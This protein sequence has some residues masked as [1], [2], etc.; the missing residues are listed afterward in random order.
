MSERTFKLTIAALGGE[1]GGVLTDWLIAIAQEEGYLVQST[2]VPGV[3]QRTGATIYYLEFFP[4]A[5]AASA[6]REPVMALMPVPGDVDCVVASELAEAGR[7]I[8]RGLVTRQTTLI[9]S[10]HRS[11][12]ISEKSA[13]GN[14]ATDREQLLELVRAQGGR[15]I[16]FDMQALAERRSAVVSAVL[17]GAI[18]GAGVLPFAKSAFEHAIT[19]AGIAVKTNMA[20]F[21]DACQQAQTGG[22]APSKPVGR[23]PP[24]PERARVAALQPLLD[25]VRQ[26][27]ERAQATALEGVRRTLDYQDRRYAE[28]YL[29]RL[30]A[31]AALETQAPSPERGASPQ[32]GTLSEAAARSLALWMTFEDPL[33]VA[34]LKCRGERFERIRTEIRAAPDKL[35]GITDF[36]KPRVAEIADTLPASWGRAVLGSKRLTRWLGHFTGGKH[37]RTSTVGGFCLLYAL[38][39][40]RRFRRATLRY[41][42]ENQR[43]EAWLG[44][45]SRLAPRNYALAVE[46]ARSQRLIKGY[47]ETHERGWA[48]FSRL[49][50]HLDGLSARPDGAEWLARLQDAALADEEGRQ[51]SQTLG[52]LA[53]VR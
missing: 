13:L 50:A 35:F 44:E 12:A 8:Q 40:M 4:G 1:G 7:A 37:I 2:S 22:A 21:E 20:A 29:S 34:Q 15:S 45:L 47:G 9:A 43:I 49:L 28:L 18:C 36:L 48:N 38:S 39:G 17:L 14:G 46:L 51:L 41:E 32:H 23:L 24:L 52:A 6:A 33:R 3:A 5:L 53:Q 19:A 16:L 25:R 30:E 42:T 31:L 27:P 10:T 26:L 11:Y